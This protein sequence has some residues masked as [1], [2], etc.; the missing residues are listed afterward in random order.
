MGLNELRSVY[1]LH[2]WQEQKEWYMIWCKYE[3]HIIY[4][5]LINTNSLQKGNVIYKIQDINSDENTKINLS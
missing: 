4:I 2:L 3:I 5:C 1:A